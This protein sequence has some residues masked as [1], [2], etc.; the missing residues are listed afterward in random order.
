MFA[1]MSKS[2]AEYLPLQCSAVQCLPE[3]AVV[4]QWRLSL[5]GGSRAGARLG[6]ATVSREQMVE[7]A[8]VR[9]HLAEEG[10]GGGHQPARPLGKASRCQWSQ[11]AGG[12][13]LKSPVDVAPTVTRGDTIV[14]SRAAKGAIHC[15]PCA[16]TATNMHLKRSHIILVPHRNSQY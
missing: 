3:A 6:E 9:L 16:D 10:R 11:R 12:V 14:H 15:S 4:V 1:Q 7:R 13:Q 8:E 5:L 2:H